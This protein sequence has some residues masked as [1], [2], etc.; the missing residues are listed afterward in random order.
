M[1]SKKD[2]D[3]GNV[4]EIRNGQKFLY[5]NI[6][7]SKILDIRGYNY[8]ELNRYDENFNRKAGKSDIFDI[9][10]VYRDYTCEEVLWERKKKP[11]LTDVEKA[12]LRNYLSKGYKWIA[13]DKEDYIYVYITKPLTMS[14]TLWVSPYAYSYGCDITFERLFQFIKWED[15]EPYSI[16]ELLEE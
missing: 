4:V 12:I 2:L 16:E 5:H 7:R 1:F 6:D 9:V 3:S 11:E 14:N 13:R 10:K 15:D 8:L